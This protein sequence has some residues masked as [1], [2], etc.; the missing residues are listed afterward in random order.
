MTARAA[1]GLR[2]GAARPGATPAQV[3]ASAA[4]GA[5]GAGTAGT[6]TT[7]SL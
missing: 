3:D 7:G 2:A 1:M 6:M 4:V 5:G